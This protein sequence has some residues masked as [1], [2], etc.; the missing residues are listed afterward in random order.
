MSQKYHNPMKT[1]TERISHRWG[2]EV[3]TRKEKQT[4]RM[5]YLGEQLMHLTEQMCQ[6]AAGRTN[7]EIEQIMKTFTNKCKPFFAESH[8]DFLIANH[9]ARRGKPLHSDTALKKLA[10]M[11]GSVCATIIGW[12]IEDA[13]VAKLSSS[14]SIE[15]NLYYFLR[16]KYGVTLMNANTYNDV[17]ENIRKYDWDERKLKHWQNFAN[18]F[19]TAVIKEAKQR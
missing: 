3:V 1:V 16:V 11:R 13:V 9:I 12:K 10:K 19:H 5:N 4:K 6:E 18:K 7:A 2:Y 15:H 8:A 17:V 14:A